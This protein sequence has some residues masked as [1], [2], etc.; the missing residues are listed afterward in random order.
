M[1]VGCGSDCLN[2]DGRDFRIGR[3]GLGKICG[4]GYIIIA[5]R[6]EFVGVLMPEGVS[7]DKRSGLEATV[8]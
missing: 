3:M 7:P 2:Q 4:V 5:R 8:L 6:G 1:G